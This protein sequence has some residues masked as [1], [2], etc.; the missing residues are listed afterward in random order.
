LWL[1]R[2]KRRS[3]A[4]KLN[5][6]KGLL[7]LPPKKK[8]GE[9]ISRRNEKRKNLPWS[10]LIPGKTYFWTIF[11]PL[12]GGARKEGRMFKERKIKVC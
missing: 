4:R 6:V 10:S 11:V 12:K 7:A 2:T 8:I 9:I 3:A 1:G 5:K